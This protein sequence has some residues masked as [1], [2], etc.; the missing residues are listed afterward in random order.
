MNHIARLVMPYL[1]SA[2]IV[3]V[4]LGLLAMPTAATSQ[5][6]EPVA[7]QIDNGI[8]LALGF[9]YCNACVGCPLLNDVPCDHATHGCLGGECD[10]FICECEEIPNNMGGFCKCLPGF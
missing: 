5:I 2:S 1:A 7:R 8:A 4:I 3:L 6:P 10:G 9:A